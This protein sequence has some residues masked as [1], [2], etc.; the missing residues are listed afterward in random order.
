MELERKNLRENWRHR[1][2]K[3][4]ARADNRCC[5]KGHRREREGEGVKEI[6]AAL[7]PYNN[8]CGRQLEPIST[9]NDSR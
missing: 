2:R 8:P 9:L 6:K 4:R 3:G 1:N 5:G 7:A